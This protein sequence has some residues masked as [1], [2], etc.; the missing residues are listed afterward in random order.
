M[1][2]NY[3][4]WNETAKK[5]AGLVLI[6]FALSFCFVAQLVFTYLGN[7]RELHAQEQ[8]ILAT[9]PITAQQE[10]KKEKNYWSLTL[11]FEKG[12]NDE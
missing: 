8:Q 4:N 6:V 5:F 9:Q 10:K 11:R 7:V 3:E 2:K 1:F 12:G